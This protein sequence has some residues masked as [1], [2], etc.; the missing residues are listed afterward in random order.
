MK[1]TVYVSV[2]ALALAG[3]A[4][5]P[6]AP[7]KPQEPPPVP[8]WILEEPRDLMGLLNRIISPFETALPALSPSSKPAKP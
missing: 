7:C 3:C 4:S 2:C 1:R 6:V 5:R 8:A